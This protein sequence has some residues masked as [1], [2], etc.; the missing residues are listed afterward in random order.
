MILRA[1]G[2]LLVCSTT[3]ALAFQDRA[4][5]PDPFPAVSSKKGLQ[6]QMVDDAL[7]LG[8]KHAALN[9]NISQLVALT[10]S[11]GTVTWVVDGAAVFLKPTALAGLD[12]QVKS[13]SDHGVVISLILLAYE[14]S[15]Q[16]LKKWLLH[17]DYSSQA[18]NRLGAFNTATPEGVRTLRACLEFIAER[19]TRPGYPHGRAANFIV[20]NEVNSHWFWYNLGRAPMEKLADEYLKAVRICHESVRKYSTTARVYLSL[21]HHWNIRYPGGDAEQAF[22]ARPFLD[23]FARRAREGGDFDWHIAFHPYPEN[24]FEPRTWNDKSA[25]L[26]NTTPRITFKN[27]EVLPAYLRQP[28]LRYHGK[29][30]R[31]I[32]S[33][34]GFHTPNGLDGEK[35]QATGYAYAWYRANNIPEI[36]S[37]ILHRHVDHAAEGGLKLGLWSR[38][39]ASKS[40]SEPA[41]KKRIY[42]V[43]LHADT[44]KWDDAFSFALPVIG[45][46][47]WEQL[48]PKTETERKAVAFLSREVPAWSR[49]NRCYSCHNNGDGARALYEAASLG[50]EVAHAALADTTAWLA[51][52]SSWDNNKGDPGFSDK[53][54]ANLQFA[55]SLVAAAAAGH[56]TNREALKI[57]ARRVAAD[58]GANGAWEIDAQSVAGSPATYGSVLATYT[59]L[60]VLKRAGTE[61]AAAAK[62]EQWLV[63]VK[64]AN[65]LETAALLLAV[66]DK[67]REKRLDVLRKAQTSDGGWGP[68]PDSPPEVF[69]TAMVLIALAQSRET[70]GAA[71]MI[72]RGRAFLI[73]TQN[74]D[75]SWLATTRPRGGESYAQQMSTTAWA[76]LALLHTR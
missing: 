30:R 7:A 58:Q 37:F 33:E 62:A 66:N 15:D 26:T 60:N 39:E 51:N 55:A 3:V 23:Y 65:L 20:G 71:K 74:A 54:L 63:N 50:H 67:S 72:E 75:G 28:E 4:V 36:D 76:T 68:F 9:V 69:D 59:A 48:F 19:Y 31:I 41:A 14:P 73:S 64:P 43:F 22:A 8:I 53:R 56:V 61:Q 52:P 11:P 13:L 25:T 24:L 70:E 44:P 6:V 16:A 35:L 32:L 1:V 34:Q 18:P 21:E 17:P 47:R 27:L 29:P 40:A 10:N 45:I 2:V 38:N 57:A 12:S 49:E 46:E 42:D 5:N